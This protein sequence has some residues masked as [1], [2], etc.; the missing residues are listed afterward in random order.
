MADLIELG[1]R[2]NTAPLAQTKA[3]AEAAA[4]SLTG[5]GRAEQDT[6]AQA[7]KAADALKKQADSAKQVT[8]QARPMQEALGKASGT[9]NATTAAVERLGGV[10]GSG[11]GGLGAN[12]GVATRALGALGEMSGSLAARLLGPVAAVGALAGAWYA[13]NKPLSQAADNYALLEARIRNALGSQDAA[14]RSLDALYKTTQETGLGFQS[15]ADSF[16]RLARNADALGASRESIL[17]LSETIQKL[18]AVSG[19]SRGEIASGLIQL[20]QA[21]ASGKLN[22]D[23]LRSIMENM[24]ALAKAIADGLGISVGQIRA[25]GAAGELTSAKV[26]DAILKA[27][28]KANEEF[29]NLPDTVERANQRTADA[30]DRL[31]VL[32]GQKW[33]SSKLVRNVSSFMGSLIT[34]ANEL[35]RPE[36]PSA[37]LDRLRAT[38]S[39][40]EEVAGSNSV[41]RPYTRRRIEALRAE[42]EREEAAGRKAAAEA[43]AAILAEEDRIARAPITRGVELGTNEYDDFTKKRKKL[44][45]DVESIDTALYILRGRAAMGTA[46]D[47]DRALIPALT[48][49]AQIARAELDNLVAGLDKVRRDMTDQSRADAIGGGAGGSSIVMKAIQQ[50]REAMT[51]GLGGSLGDF[52]GAGVSEAVLRGGDQIGTLQRQTQAQITLAAAVGGTRDQ[53]RELEIANEV[54]NKRFEMFGKLSG[55]NIVD[56]L[57]RYTEALRAS[58][59]AADQMANAQARLSET[60]NLRRSEIKLDTVGLPYEQRRRMMELE[61]VEAIRKGNPELAN[62]IRG[63]FGVDET[64]S[65][66]TQIADIAYG[67]ETNRML[68]GVGMT[69]GEQREIE[70]QRRIERSLLGVAPG[71]RGALE[72]AMRSEAE[73]QRTREYSAQETALQR[74]LR[75]LQERTRFMGLTSDELRVQNALLAKRTQ[76]ENDGAPQDVIDR[77]MAITEEIERQTIAYEKQRQRVDDLFAVVD[78]AAG[79]FKSTFVGVFEE[80][81]KTGKIN[82]DRFFNDLAGMVAKAGAEFAYEVGVRPFV[83]AA[84]NW[85]KS[86]LQQLLPGLFGGGEAPVELGG[87]TDS[88]APQALGGAFGPG[89]VIPFAMGGVVTR[90]TLFAF[91]NGG[92]LGVMGEAG[93]EAIMPLKRGADGKLGVAGAGVSVIV[94]DYRTGGAPVG[95]EERTGPDGRKLISVI[96]RDEVKRSMRNGEMDRDMATNFGVARPV[97]RM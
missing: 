33:D 44:L 4:Q 56:F 49:Q 22:G 96:V 54:A 20:S 36:S 11:V 62:I 67:T 81:F 48:R 78:T 5:L 41:G 95:V 23:E 68:S 14:K 30:W 55:Q 26:F 87:W 18:G 38:L 83:T 91:G 60:M 25:L 75:T 34:S 15:A 63:R 92:R 45:G 61:A 93:E 66:R 84:S 80:A 16:A 40:L 3:L 35:L 28:A 57:S 71:E 32:L 72:G 58:K 64:A 10:L 51:K 6:A 65:A 46:N 79:G 17:K 70:L 82:A 90:P 1:F 24:P 29:A 77:Q 88:I 47:Q 19:A 9:I 13:V 50:Q 27:S 53:V 59:V 39:G 31:L 69:A 73:S 8:D 2:I 94:N 85:A 37:N 42:I 21:L 12:I 86:G 97:M 7:Q 74:Q 89:G 52:I 76:L 43:S